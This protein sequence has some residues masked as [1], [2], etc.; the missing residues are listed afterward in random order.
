MKITISLTLHSISRK[1]KNTVILFD[2]MI[3]NTVHLFSF[4]KWCTGSTLAMYY[5]YNSNVLSVQQ[6]CTGSTLAMYFIVSLF[7]FNNSWFY[8]NLT[9]SI[10]TIFLFHNIC[11]LMFVKITYFIFIFLWFYFVIIYKCSI[12]QIEVR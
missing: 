3:Q 11:I 5:Q 4:F 1:T 9:I 10:F 6:Q 2:P 12:L 7:H 8:F